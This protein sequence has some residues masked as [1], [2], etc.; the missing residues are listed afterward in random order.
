MSHFVRH[1]T[2]TLARHM[3]IILLLCTTVSHAQD[4]SF[5]WPDGKSMAL[6]LTFDDA[7]LSQADGGAA[8]LDEY[9]VKATF[10]VVPAQVQE[11][12]EGWKKI[13]ANG[14]EIGNHTL[15]HPCSGNYPWSR[16]KAL[17]DYNLKAMRE[18]MEACNEQIDKLLGVRATLFAYP[19]GHTYV[20]RGANTK[21]YIPLVAK[22]FFAGRTYRDNISNDPSFC[23][24]AQLTGID[25]DGKDFDDI[26]SLLDRARQNNHWLILGG[27]EMGESGHQTTRIAMLR[28]L[29]EYAHDPANGIWIAPMGT[30]A[31]YISER[32]K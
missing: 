22:M 27:H 4:H 26:T 23:D 17:E 29:L 14:H 12:L 25:M 6:S 32:R 21:S 18:E 8:L 13:V 20:G 5:S 24:L 28:A 10:F 31:Q 2:L 7:R 30:V 15:T 9:G 11:R 19:C 1:P 3:G 16:N